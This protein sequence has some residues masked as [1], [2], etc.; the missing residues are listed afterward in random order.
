TRGRHDVARVRRAP[1]GLRLEAGA[2]AANRSRAARGSHGGLKSQ[3]AARLGSEIRRDV[4]KAVGGRITDS[5]AAARGSDEAA[6]QRI[7][8]G[9]FGSAGGELRVAAEIDALEA[10]ALRSHRAF[11]IG[12]ARQ[13]VR[14]RSEEHTSELQ[15]RE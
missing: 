13:A 10:H 14:V 6:L 1:R 2:K 9:G 11:L 15:S 8:S 4:A 7:Q 5:A 3:D 12:L